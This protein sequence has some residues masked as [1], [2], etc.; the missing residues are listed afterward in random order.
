MKKIRQLAQK[1]RKTGAVLL[2]LCLLAG[3]MAFGEASPRIDRMD[4]FTNDTNISESRYKSNSNVKHTYHSIFQMNLAGPGLTAW[5][6]ATGK[7]VNVAVFDGG[8]DVNDKE[9][10]PNIKGCYNAFTDQEGAR[11]INAQTHGT[12]CAKVLAAAGNNK[13]ASAGVA[14]NANLYLVQI[15]NEKGE[16]TYYEAMDAFY[17][18]LEYA[19]KN[20]CRVISYSL[21]GTYYDRKEEEAIRELYYQP[22]N[23]ILFVSSAG[24]DN[25]EEYRYPAAFD[26]ALGVSALKYENKKYT[27][28][29]SNYH[30]KIDLAAPGP[31]TSTATPYVAGTAALVF[32]V[33]SSLTAAQCRKI[34][35]DT[36]TDA[37]D[38]GFDKRYGYGIVDPLAAVQSA[39][40]KKTFIGR[41]ILG[42]KDYYEYDLAD[43]KAKLSP[44]ID[45]SGVCTY[46]SSNS[47]VVS[48]DS[49]GI[50][51]FHGR[52]TAKITISVEK[53]GIY[54]PASKTVTV[55][56]VQRTVPR[57]SLKKMSWKEG[58]PGKKSLILQ[59]K[60]QKNAD[61]YQ[62]LLAKNKAFTKGRKT[63]FIKK[64][65]VT[66]KTIKKLS[67][68]TK[69][70]VK[71]RAY[72]KNGTRKKYGSFSSVKKIKTK[73]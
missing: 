65:T 61:G 50:M 68:R 7:G 67:A 70:Y 46:S 16:A 15:R 12:N 38:P 71:I 13:N 24:N 14:Y 21:S 22:E 5:D 25:K 45:G 2:A 56:V 10:K 30:D 1:R 31:S 26:V 33:D 48:V 51:T 17:R 40:Y 9:L 58:K 39:K 3:V 18:G 60:R 73:G 29:T 41:S 23:S 42:M 44:M 36:A 35:T 27:I 34:L 72:Q 8:F 62:I 66:K 28:S 59:W 20:N 11:Y 53:S 47:A 52:G 4:S 55:K 6:Y 54:L 63:I 57:P 43:K 37:G 69:Y 49:E 19:K 64:N 32:S